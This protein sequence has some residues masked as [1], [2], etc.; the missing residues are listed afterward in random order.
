MIWMGDDD[1]VA[2]VGH[3]SDPVLGADLVFSLVDGRCRAALQGPVTSRVTYPHVE[4]GQYIG[5]RFR[6][7]AAE[8]TIGP[9][10]RDLCDQSIE[11]ERF[12]RIDLY[13]LGDRLLAADSL[14]DRRRLVADRVLG[15]SM[16][17][18]APDSLVSAA[19]DQFE[20]SDAPRVAEVAAALGSSERR[21]Q[22]AFSRHLGVAPKHVARVVRVRR[23]VELLESTT[24][25][26]LAN[27]AVRAGFYDQS[28]MTNDVRRLLDTTP[29][30]IVDEQIQ[31][32]AWSE[33]R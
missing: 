9:A 28:H 17:S 1:V 11:L 4:G 25:L 30:A 19:L 22:R 18:C 14:L 15:E 33:S 20:N 23:L 16:V 12:G 5:V 2:G 27:A 10:L 7:G 3:R 8:A 24:D 6:P 32:K 21:L 13:E 26:D 31:R 29:G